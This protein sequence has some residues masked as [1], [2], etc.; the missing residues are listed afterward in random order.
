[1]AA[2]DI[3]EIKGASRHRRHGETG[4]PRELRSAATVRTIEIEDDGGDALPARL[5]MHGAAGQGG[6]E[7]VEMG[8]V[9]VARAVM[10]QLKALAI[11]GGPAGQLGDAGFDAGDEIVLTAIEAGKSA[12]PR[13]VRH[14]AA[15]VGIHHGDG[16]QLLLAQLDELGAFLRAQHV[17]DH[18][19]ART[20]QPHR[21]AHAMAVDLGGV[22]VEPQVGQGF[23][24]QRLGELAGGLADRLGGGQR[25]RDLMLDE[26]LEN[27]GWAAAALNIFQHPVLPILRQLREHAISFPTLGVHEP[28]EAAAALSTTR[29]RHQASGR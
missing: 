18:R 20:F 28:K 12:A 16:A 26:L 27:V 11:L 14:V 15:A 29:R 21:P 2:V 5:H 25:R 10:D 13:L 1:M 22:A 24:F 9:L 4:Q 6:V 7:P 8:A 3:V 17:L 23:G 19:D